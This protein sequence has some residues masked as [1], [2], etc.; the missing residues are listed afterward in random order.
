MRIPGGGWVF[1]TAPVAQGLIAAPGVE[2][3]TPA[4]PVLAPPSRGAGGVRRWLWSRKFPSAP[5]TDAELVM[6]ALTAAHADH[7]AI[8]V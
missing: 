5:L 4:A 7:Q 2:L 8:S 1:C 3:V 6:S